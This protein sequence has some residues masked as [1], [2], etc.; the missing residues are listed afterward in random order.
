M[1]TGKDPSAPN[2]SPKMPVACSSFHSRVENAW[3]SSIPAISGSIRSADLR[4]R[5]RLEGQDLP[6]EYGHALQVD[7]EQPV[8]VG[9]RARGER[10]NHVDPG[11]VDQHVHRPEG[12]LDLF[13]RAAHRCA[14]GHV[15][16]DARGARA[17]DAC[18]RGHGFHSGGRLRCRVAIDITDRD[19]G[20]GRREGVRDGAPDPSRRAGNQHGLIRK[21]HLY[22]RDFSGELAAS[23]VYLFR[24]L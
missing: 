12:F 5:S 14:V 17:G 19:A 15:E 1:K 2:G 21:R 8:P 24:R 13:D 7:G 23:V 4:R 6:G 11:V 18:G 20:A 22:L 16:L 3:L 9:L 10:A